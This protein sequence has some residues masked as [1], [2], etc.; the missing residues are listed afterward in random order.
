[1]ALGG[2]LLILVLFSSLPSPV[3]K[4]VEP[5]NFNRYEYIDAS[6]KVS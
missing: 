5:S 2:F 1:M 3:Q 6:R 4:A